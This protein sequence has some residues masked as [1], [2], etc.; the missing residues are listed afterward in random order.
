MAQDTSQEMVLFEGF[1]WLNI[2]TSS[3]IKAMSWNE[4]HSKLHVQFANGDVYEYDGIKSALVERWEDKSHQ[5]TYSL[6]Q[7]FNREVADNPVIY[8]YRRLG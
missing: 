2:G 6:G 4:Q 1:R 3:M 8:P 5:P 7:D